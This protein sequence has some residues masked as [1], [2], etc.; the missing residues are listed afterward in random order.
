MSNLEWFWKKAVAKERLTKKL[1]KKMDRIA[2]ENTLVEVSKPDISPTILN[3]V[4]NLHT[5][6]ILHTDLIDVSIEF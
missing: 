3:G 5:D 1:K 4:N 6:E 2:G